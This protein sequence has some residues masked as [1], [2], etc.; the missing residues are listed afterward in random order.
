MLKQ[1][2]SNTNRGDVLKLSEQRAALYGARFG[3]LPSNT[4]SSGFCP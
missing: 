4:C 1:S 2:R 3:G